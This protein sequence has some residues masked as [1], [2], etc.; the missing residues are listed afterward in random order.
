MSRDLKL[1]HLC[2]H[3][4]VDETLAL[5]GGLWPLASPPSSSDVSLRVDDIQVTQAGL[6]SAADYLSEVRSPFV[7]TGT[8][9]RLS[10]STDGLAYSNLVVAPGRYTVEGLRLLIGSYF[11]VVDQAGYPWLRSRT[12]GQGGVLAFGVPSIAVTTLSGGTPFGWTPASTSARETDSRTTFLDAIVAQPYAIGAGATLGL[13]LDGTVVAIPLT[14]GVLVASQVA[15]LV[16]AANV[17]R[18]SAS[19]HTRADGSVVVRLEATA[20]SA[21]AA[22]GLPENRVFRGQ[23]LIP[24]WSVV[25]PSV[26]DEYQ[27]AVRFSTDLGRTD[28]PV[29][30]TYRAIPDVCP[31]CFGSRQENDF[32]YDGL[33]DP[34]FVEE[35]ALLVQDLKKL[36]LTVLGSNP[37]HRWYGTSLV[38]LLGAK[39]VGPIEARISAEI[40]NAMRAWTSIKERQ[41]RIQEVTDGEVPYRMT[42]LS[43]VRDKVDP[44]ILRVEMEVLSRRMRPIPI[45]VEV[46]E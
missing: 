38:A 11:R 25:R 23:Q 35:E 3:S 20:D 21:H 15:D 7:V 42:D 4:I 26:L 27:R 33:G 44:A 45:V 37:F 2:P 12:L 41:G 6:L 19:I 32:R 24:A 18:L 36:I 16:I 13:S 31:R 40:A 5:S 1:A 43:V 28:A 8:R 9:P 29:D 34:V 22:F 10:V 46:S 30:A 17:P 14:A 39:A